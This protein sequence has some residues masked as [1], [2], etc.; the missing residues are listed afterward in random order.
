M[1]YIDN[2]GNALKSEEQKYRRKQRQKKEVSI[3]TAQ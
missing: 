1:F 3:G 2:A